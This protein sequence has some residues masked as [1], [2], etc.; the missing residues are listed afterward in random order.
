MGPLHALCLHRTPFTGHHQRYAGIWT[1]EE[2][3]SLRV[4]STNRFF[5]ASLAEVHAC[6]VY[7]NK[8][9]VQRGRQGWENS[10]QGFYYL[11]WNRDWSFWSPRETNWILLNDSICWNAEA[12]GRRQS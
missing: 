4:L 6:T 10:T 5:R 12:K 8:G 7:S 3:V 1:G 11:V 9:N 2:P